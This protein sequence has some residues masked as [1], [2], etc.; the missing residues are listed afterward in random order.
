MSQESWALLVAFPKSELQIGDGA[1][2][3]DLFAVLRLGFNDLPI[4]VLPAALDTRSETVEAAARPCYQSTR[5]LASTAIDPALATTH[6]A[7]PKATIEHMVSRKI[8]AWRRN[9]YDW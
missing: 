4:N 7:G 6:V 5:Q 8:V 3:G 2:F 9:A 1:W